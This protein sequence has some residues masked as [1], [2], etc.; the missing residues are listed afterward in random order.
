MRLGR[1]D[2]EEGSSQ[3]S[4]RRESDRQPFFRRQDSFTKALRAWTPERLG[5]AMS[6]LAGASL[7]ARKSKRPELA[8][9]IAHRALMLVA[10]GAGRREAA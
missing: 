1:D 8:D 6:M 4:Y 2:A 9:T 10:R 5:R 3:P 7:D